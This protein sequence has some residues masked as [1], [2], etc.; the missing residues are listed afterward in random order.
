MCHSLQ[1]SKMRP[2][3]EID[4]V[5]LAHGRKTVA[6]SLCDEAQVVLVCLLLNDLL[7]SLLK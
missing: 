3:A 2:C 7:D 6:F 1:L 5:I 4:K